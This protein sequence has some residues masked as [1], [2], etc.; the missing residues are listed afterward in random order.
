MNLLSVLSHITANLKEKHELLPAFGS[1]FKISSQELGWNKYASQK[2][3]SLLALLPEFPFLLGFV[4]TR[5]IIACHMPKHIQLNCRPMRATQCHQPVLLCLRV[6]ACV[7]V[8]EQPIFLVCL[9]LL[10]YV[11]DPAHYILKSRIGLYE[12]VVC[13]KHK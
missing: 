11:S 6:L 5:T 12:I 4:E 3:V 7:C 2:A 13:F 8:F 9:S 1:T 10:L